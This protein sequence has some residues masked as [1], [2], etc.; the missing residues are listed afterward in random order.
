MNYT[1]EAVDISKL[2]YVLGSIASAVAFKKTN[3]LFSDMYARTQQACTDPSLQG[4][5][6]QL[7]CKIKLERISAERSSLKDA[8]E[9]EEMYMRRQKLFY[10][11][12]DAM[13]NSQFEVKSS[14][15]S[16]HR[17]QREL[18]NPIDL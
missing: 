2:K 16:A 8:F 11:Q 18:L 9:A 3:A 13:R 7:D 17:P 1:E 14:E 10:E 6:A 15:R 4:Q 5:T 12:V